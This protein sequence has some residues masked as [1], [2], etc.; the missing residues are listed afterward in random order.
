MQTHSLLQKFFKHEAFEHGK[1][2]QEV[3]PLLNWGKKLAQGL[4]QCLQVLHSKAVKCFSSFLTNV[5]SVKEACLIVL[6]IETERFN[7]CLGDNYIVVVQNAKQGASREKQE[8]IRS[9][10]D[11]TA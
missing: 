11:A 5:N 6:N 3:N 8:I 4:I 9:S 10:H 2:N 1:V 7:Y